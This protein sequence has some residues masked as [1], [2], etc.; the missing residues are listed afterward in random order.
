MDRSRNGGGTGR[1]SGMKT[2]VRCRTCGFV[3]EK[4]RLKDVCP[5][6]G[7]LAKLFEPYEPRMSEARRKVLGFHIHPILVH[8]P[9]ALG[10]LIL[11]FAAGLFAVN[12][13]LRSDLY[14]AL[15]VLAVLQPLFVLLSFVSG[16]VDGKLRYRR[17]TTPLLRL[18]TGLGI[19]LF[20]L[21]L[22][23]PAALRFTGGTSMGLILVT[24]LAL[25][26]FAC[27]ILLGL[28]GASLAE[29]AVA[30]NGR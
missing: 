28:K 8:F 3:M 15:T 12:E 23:V 29:G 19:A 16:L 1:E 5:A 26:G 21:S 2:Y 4:G 17:T 11:L 10:A 25:G 14:T 18:K 30:G 7:V 27:S 6:C 24:V 20:V 13:P 22:A 9:Q